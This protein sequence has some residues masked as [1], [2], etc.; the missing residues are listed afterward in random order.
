VERERRVHFVDDFKVARTAGWAQERER[1]CLLWFWHNGVGQ[2]LRKFLPEALYC[3]AGKDANAAIIDPANKNRITIASIAAH[4]IGKNLQHFQEQL[5]VQWPRVARDAEQALGRT[6]RTGQQAD[7]LVVWRFDVLP[8]DSLNFAA[9]L[10]DSVYN[11]QSTGDRQK[12][13][14][15]NYNP[16]PTVFSPEFLKEQGADPHALSAEQTRMMEDLFGAEWKSA[17]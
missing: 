9:C 8:F 13:V 3:P 10:N 1:G 12:M 2:W 6:H 14:Y 11:H 7:D 5:F 15:A 4:G 16:M 17:L